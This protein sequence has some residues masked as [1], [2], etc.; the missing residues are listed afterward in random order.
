[1]WVRPKHS[2][3]VAFISLP[4]VLDLRSG[5]GKTTSRSPTSAL[6][7]PFLGEGSRTKIC[8]SKSWY[9]LIVTSLLSGGSKLRPH[10]GLLLTSLSYC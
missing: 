5:F 3:F 4:E 6:S 8:Y 7:H 2:G 10:F 9:Q 1:M